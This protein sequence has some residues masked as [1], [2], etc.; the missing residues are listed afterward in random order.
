MRSCPLTNTEHAICLGIGLLSFLQAVLVK[1]FLPVRWFAKFHMNE[2]AMSEEEAEQKFTGNFRKSFRS[3]I[4][5]S[6]GPSGSKTQ[7]N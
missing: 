4:R 1:A 5:R 2:E 6:N 3:S 7:I